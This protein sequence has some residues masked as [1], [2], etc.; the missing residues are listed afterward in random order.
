MKS[1]FLLESTTPANRNIVFIN[2]KKI[3]NKNDNMMKNISPI[4]ESPI[5]LPFDIYGLSRI[6]T[7]CRNEATIAI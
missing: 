2:V 6:I 1:L 7:K 4:V 5:L 3:I